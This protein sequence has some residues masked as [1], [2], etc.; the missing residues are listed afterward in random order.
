M[1]V[2]V[3]VIEWLPALAVIVDTPGETHISCRVNGRR[4]TVAGMPTA[5]TGS[6]AGRHPPSPMRTCRS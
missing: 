5:R 3:L 6:A 4:G 2:M 1:S